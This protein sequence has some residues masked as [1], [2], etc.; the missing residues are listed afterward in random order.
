MAWIRPSR[1]E[2]TGA[3]TMHPS[4]DSGMGSFSRYKRIGPETFP[5]AEPV[6]GVSS[7]APEPVLRR[8]TAVALVNPVV[9]GV[10]R[11]F[12][13]VSP[14]AASSRS[15][16]LPTASSW[17]LPRGLDWQIRLRAA[18]I[19]PPSGRGMLPEA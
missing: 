11:C 7:T 1:G 8:L 4:T 10:R 13:T 17:A 12:V 3:M 6:M 16:K 15:I 5:S 2:V 19:R 9:S 18:R 14:A